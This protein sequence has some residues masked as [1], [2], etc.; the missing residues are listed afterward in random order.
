VRGRWPGGGVLEAAEAVRAARRRAGPARPGDQLL[1]GVI[2]LLTDGYPAGAPVLGRALAAF[3]ETKVSL[4]EG[5]G[6]L[7]L[8][9]RLSAEVW[10]DHSW[11]VLSARLI[12]LARDAGA[13]SL[14]PAPLTPGAAGHP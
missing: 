2:T 9:G 10:D 14:L 12:E 13:L 11:S 7:P 3:A 4:E 5:L 1:D 8:A 6:W